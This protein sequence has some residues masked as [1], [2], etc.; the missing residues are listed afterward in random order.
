MPCYTYSLPAKNCHRGSKLHE[1]QGSVCSKCYARRGNFSR[2]TIQAGME[3]RLETIE[4]P[5]WVDAMALVLQKMEYSGFFR[6]HASGDVQNLGH[7]IKI[8][9]VARRLPNIRFWLPTHEFGIIGDY[10]RAGFKIPD[11]LIIRLSA[12]MI[13]QSAPKR[14]M[15]DYGVLGGRVSKVKWDCPAPSQ[16][17]QCLDC[18]RCWNKRIKVVTY[19]YH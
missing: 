1:I 6:W 19:K 13:E 17:N 12:D 5:R 15:D 3:K 16:N 4:H 14:L 9:E 2:P 7:L 10:V 11:N 18:R 8:A